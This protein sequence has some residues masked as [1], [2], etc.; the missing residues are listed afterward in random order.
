MATPPISLGTADSVGIAAAIVYFVIGALASGRQLNPLACAIGED[1]RYSSSKLQF[2]LWTGIV[3]WA[4]VALFV[5]WLDLSKM[6]LPNNVL[7]VMGFSIITLTTAKGVTTAYV[8]S[9]RLL[10]P[11]A[12]R[13][14]AITDLFTL[15]NSDTPDLTKIQMLSWTLIA[16]GIYIFTVWG[17][18]SQSSSPTIFPNID[19]TL[20]ALMGIGQGAYL[21][22]KIV[23]QGPNGP[24]LTDITPQKDATGS[25]VQLKGINLGAQ[26]VVLFGNSPVQPT[27]WNATTI[28]FTVPSTDGAGKALLP[29]QD[30]YVAALSAIDVGTLQSS[31]TVK[32]TIA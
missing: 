23:A 26:G 14:P 22:M 27:Q 16:I 17:A 6:Q 21:G 15:D 11:P 30:V 31:N 32:F 29:G 7:L 9:G 3:I 28:A 10:K 13:K 1:G 20:M 2:F 5:R 8:N 19:A 4:Y 24:A 18:L 12:L 25:N